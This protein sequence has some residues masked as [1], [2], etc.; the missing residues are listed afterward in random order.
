MRRAEV[1]MTESGIFKIAI[2]LAPEERAAYL[3]QACGTD[4]DLRRD[5][6][7]LLHEHDCSAGSPA[8]R[9]LTRT[10]SGDGREFVLDRMP[11]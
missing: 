4:A 3:S 2:K 5:V 1:N 9:P 6:E 7:S 10:S 11:E 8:E